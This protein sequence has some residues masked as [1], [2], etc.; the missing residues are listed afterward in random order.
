MPDG[1]SIEGSIDELCLQIQS[2]E[3]AKGFARLQAR[4]LEQWL[5]YET[6][7]HVSDFVDAPQAPQG[8][9]EEPPEPEAT[10]PF[11]VRLGPMIRRALV[12]DGAE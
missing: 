8:I 6:S 12:L 3:A 4:N 1:W 11:N 7:R 5:L 10:E 2:G 9:R